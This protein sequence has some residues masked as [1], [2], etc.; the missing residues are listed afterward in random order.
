MQQKMLKL[1]LFCIYIPSITKSH[2]TN[3]GANSMSPLVDRQK[4]EELFLLQYFITQGQRTKRFYH[5]HKI[6]GK[7][8]NLFKNSEDA[9]RRQKAQNC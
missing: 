6:S 3:A 5:Q 8:S 1:F 2:S 9:R 7:F 4:H